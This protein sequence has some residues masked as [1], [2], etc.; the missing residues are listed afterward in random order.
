MT[1]SNTVFGKLGFKM[2]PDVQ[3]DVE[4][5]RALRGVDFDREF[6]NMMVADHKKAIEMFRH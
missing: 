1:I 2:A 5:M 4:R 3:K 6:M